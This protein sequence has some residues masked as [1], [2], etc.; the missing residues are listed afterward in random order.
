MT[1]DRPDLAGSPQGRDAACHWFRSLRDRVI[2]AFESIED[3]CNGP[4]RDRPPGAI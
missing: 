1:T 2:A 3:A 4:G